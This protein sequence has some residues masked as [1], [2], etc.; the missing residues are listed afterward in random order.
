MPAGSVGALGALLHEDTPVR[1]RAIAEAMVSSAEPPQAIAAG[2]EAALELPP[3]HNPYAAT[4]NRPSR[5]LPLRP[6]PEVSHVA[7]VSHALVP[8]SASRM[9]CEARIARPPQTYTGCTLRRVTR[10]YSTHVSI[11]RSTT[12]K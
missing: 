10:S 1:K 9:T 6:H 2:I 11:R 7:T 12:P 3:R 4:T 8:L 5:I